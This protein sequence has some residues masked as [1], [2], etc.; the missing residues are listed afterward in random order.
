M[1]ASKLALLKKHHV[2]LKHLVK[3]TSADCIHIV[4]GMSDEVIKLLSEICI[5]VM[6]KSLTR[7]HNYAVLKLSPF[8]KQL[9]TVTRA[10][11]TIT[12]KRKTFQQK[13]G[14][15]GALLGIALPLI[16]SLIGAAAGR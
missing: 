14:F 6:N 10:N 13:G 2:L 7:D 8:K 15:I 12:H 4:E 11:T 5:N 3:C 16:T 1:R 9:K